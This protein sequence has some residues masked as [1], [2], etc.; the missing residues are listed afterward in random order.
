[1]DSFDSESDDLEL[2]SEFSFEFSFF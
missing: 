2:F 1:M